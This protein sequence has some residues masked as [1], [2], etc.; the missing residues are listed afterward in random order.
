[1]TY[2]RHPTFRIPLIPRC[3]FQLFWFVSLL[4][5]LSFTQP[6]DGDEDFQQRFDTW[7]KDVS[8]NGLS[9]FDSQSKLFELFDSPFVTNGFLE[10]S[11]RYPHKLSRSPYDLKVYLENVEFILKNRSKSFPPKKVSEHCEEPEKQR[12]CIDY[13][14]KNILA[15][16]APRSCVRNKITLDVHHQLWLVNDHDLL[17]WEDYPKNKRP[18]QRYSVPNCHI[19]LD[20]VKSPAPWVSCCWEMTLRN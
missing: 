20:K 5:S 12:V 19:F 13:V 1:M 6:H 3:G 9:P 10:Y 15:P 18:K 8:F 17:L 7:T 14:S 16:H 4:S 11:T 2:S